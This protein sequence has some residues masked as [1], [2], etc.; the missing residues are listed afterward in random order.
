M[1]RVQILLVAPIVLLALSAEAAQRAFVASTGNDANTATSC[2]FTSPCRSFAAAMTVIEPKGEIVAL[3]AAGYGAVTID[4]SVTLTANPGVFAGI[5]ASTGN[6]VTIATA[7]VNVV[8]RNLNINGTGAANGV[9]MSAGTRLTIENC[10]I[11]NFSG[12]G[13]HAQGGGAMRLRVVDTVVRDNSVGVQVSDG[14]EATLTRTTLMGNSNAALRVT[15]NIGSTTT[16]NL[17]DS[18]VT[19]NVNAGIW[20]EGLHNT[21]TARIFVTR[22]AVTTSLVALAA[23]TGP[24][25]A[26]VTVGQSMV[27][28][29]GYGHYTNGPGAA[30]YSSGNN[31]FA[32]NTVNEGVFTYLAPQ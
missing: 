6:A 11:S 8:L 16:A 14:A 5:A 26:H 22:T 32:G 12:W 15:N 10:V 21:G 31:T 2:V 29:N 17:N 9:V 27:S 24:G 13:V 3:D 23:T 20:A 1:P 30:I 25:S 4:K 28:A 19:D 18:V 7:S